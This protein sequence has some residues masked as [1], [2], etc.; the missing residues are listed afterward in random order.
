MSILAAPAGC[1]TPGPKG[2]DRNWLSDLLSRASLDD[3]GDESV[4]IPNL[5]ATIPAPSNVKA[6]AAPTASGKAKAAS[7]GKAPAEAEP[8]ADAKSEVDARS[9][10]EAKFASEAKSPNGAKSPSDDKVVAE[11]GRT[12]LEVISADIARMIDHR[13]AVELWERYR[14]GEPNLF[15]ESLYTAQGRQTFEEVRRRYA[16]DADFRR[17]V[18]R[19]VAEFERL[20]EDVSRNDRDAKRTDAYLTS[21]TGKVYTML[22]HASGR[23]EGA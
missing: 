4:A 22:A 8:A 5:P 10:G 2:A 15:D 3:D 20:M 21:E 14:R 12:A 23:F 11:R 7:K 18:D 16:A 9:A 1:A 13:T 19:Y 6:P 17:T